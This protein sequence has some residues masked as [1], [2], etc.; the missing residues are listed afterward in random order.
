MIPSV[1]LFSMVGLPLRN[2]LMT[3]MIFVMTSLVF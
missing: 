2:K 3:Q 1:V